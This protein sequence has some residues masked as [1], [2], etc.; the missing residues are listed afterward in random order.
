VTAQPD[1]IPNQRA[2]RLAR[3]SAGAAELSLELDHRVIDTMLRYVELLEKWNRTHNLT[4]VR[5]IDEMISRHLLDSLSIIPHVVGT[6]VLDV[7]SGAGLPGIPLAI[8]QPHLTV[9]LIDSVQKKTRFQQFCAAQLSL[10]NI[11]PMHAR[12][13]RIQPPPAYDTIV[14]RA[15]AASEK[16]LDLTAHLL[17]DGGQ[18]LAMTAS[19]EYRVGDVTANGFRVAK[20]KKLSVPGEN[21]DRNI[22]IFEPIISP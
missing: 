4:A 5:Q 8:A 11:A 22:V 20:Q 14:A 3:L 16:L 12:V 9:T 15:F 21:A 7:G 2:A 10:Q 6:R 19:T 13:E 18:V 1:D 17:A